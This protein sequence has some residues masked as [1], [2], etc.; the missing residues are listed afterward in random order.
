M[1][2]F[3]SHISSDK[4]NVK[5]IM[6][7]MPMDISVW[8]DEKNLL[9][10]SDLS[11]TF[12][13]VIKT[14]C[15][16]VL[17]FLNKDTSKWVL[18]ELKWAKEKQDDIQRVF[19]IPIIM[20]NVVGDPYESFPQIEGMKY[21]KLSGYEETDLEACAKKI[22][23]HLFGLIVNELDIL[24]DSK[25]ITADY[26]SNNDET[27]S[28]CIKIY[29]IIFKHR[30]NN[31][32]T[33]K[34]LYDI[35]KT[36]K[37]GDYDFEKFMLLLNYAV[38]QMP[39]IDFDGES[40]YLIEE[41]SKLKNLFA[42]EKKKI[43]A[44]EAAKYVKKHQTIFIDA[45]STMNELV[46]V[47]CNKIKCKSITDINFIVLSTKQ[48]SLISDVCASL[49]YDQDNSPIRLYMPGGL[50]RPNTKAIV[51]VD[52]KVSELNYL[53]DTFNALDIAFVGANGATLE[54]GITT[55][56]NAELLNKKTVIER[57]QNVYFL[58]DDSKCGITC[59][60]KLSDFVDEKIK[61]IINESTDNDALKEIVNEHRDSIILAKKRN[62]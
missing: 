29:E 62:D 10:G 54:D 30:Q 48:A 53:I 1:K 35:M 46:N 13:K 19:I 38:S 42:V 4:S 55:H 24:K 14:E 57:A 9:S 6:K 23:N 5:A 36:K 58:F 52:A 31:P 7:Y 16:Y 60:K 51:D 40:L 3:L 61:I 18:D 49:G 12:E 11:S 27:M 39:G 21:I 26:G 50:V 47:L 45:G 25:K 2:I 28:L 43:I 15:D 41:H 59:E 33:S 34:K 37:M 32:I 20:N 56:D 17:V 44:Q 8:L 22:S